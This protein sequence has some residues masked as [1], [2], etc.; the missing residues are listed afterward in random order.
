MQLLTAN[1]REDEVWYKSSGVASNKK[2]KLC[3]NAIQYNNCNWIVD[4]PENQYCYSCNLTKVIPN[5]SNLKNLERWSKIEAFKRRLLYTL[6]SLG[7]DVSATTINHPLTLSFAFLE[8]QRTNPEIDLEHVNTGH[9]QGLITVNVAEADDEYLEEERARFDELYRTVL[10][11]L[12]HESGHFIFDRLIVG[13]PWIE[14]FRLLFGDERENYHAALNNYYASDSSDNWSFE[15]ISKY[16]QSHPLEDWAETW[17]HYL[18][19]IDTTE[20]AQWFELIRQH[21]K[22]FSGQEFL[23]DWRHL[24]VVLNELNRSMGL[25][26]AYPFTISNAVLVKLQF[27]HQVVLA[28]TNVSLAS[29]A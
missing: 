7:L 1:N 23:R 13:S 17:A 18:H 26:D 15:Y 10:G 29:G 3:A 4:N 8:D 19:I 11:H 24:V 2:I 9:N 27:I 25:K 12:R 6:L 22:P 14:K 28:S 20:T 5:L 21:I 16:A